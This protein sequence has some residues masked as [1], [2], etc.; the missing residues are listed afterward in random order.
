MDGNFTLSFT[1]T[2]FSQ[3]ITQLIEITAPTMLLISHV[4]SVLFGCKEGIV[5]ERTF[6]SY[7]NNIETIR[8]SEITFKV[9][10]EMHSNFGCRESIVYEC[11]FHSYN[12]NIETIRRSEITFKVENEM[13]SK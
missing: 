3:A 7:N 10:N 11:T 13:H 5:Y 6:H 9:E 2:P 1:P 12:N 8:R 4:E